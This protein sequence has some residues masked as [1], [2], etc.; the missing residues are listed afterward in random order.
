MKI[1]PSVM[2]PVRSGMGWVMSV[3]VLVWFGQG[4]ITQ[5]VVR[6]SQD[7]DLSN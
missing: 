6:H 5:T 2:Y 7:R 1:W 4:G 3:A